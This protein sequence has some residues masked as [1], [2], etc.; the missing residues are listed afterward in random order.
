VAYYRLWQELR[1]RPGPGRRYKEKGCDAIIG[2]GGGSSIDLG[3]G[4][5]LLATHAPPLVGYAMVCRRRQQC[6]SV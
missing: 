4:V 3:K 6:R 2:F 1:Q 5:R